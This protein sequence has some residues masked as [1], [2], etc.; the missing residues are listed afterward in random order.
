MTSNADAVD[1]LTIALISDVFFQPDE[2]PRL[3]E[4]LTHARSRGADLAVLP[5]IPLNPW[6]PATETP[7]EHDAEAP[8]GPRHQ[9]LSDAAR[10]AGIGVVGGAIVRDPKSGRRHNTSLVFDGA[11]TLVGS[12]RKLHLPDE[13]GF[14][15]T[16]HYDPG[17]ALPSVIGA[18]RMRVGL[19]VCSDVNRAE[20]SRLLGALGA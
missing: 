15:E 3:V 18:F 4:L 12:Y 11:G 13:K 20:G 14:W 8:G 7:T 6:S 1:A 10:A 16:R 5:E 2:A 19:Q 17:D 9:A